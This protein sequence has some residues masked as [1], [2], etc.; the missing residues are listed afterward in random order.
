MWILPFAF[1]GCGRGPE[2]AD[3]GSALCNVDAD[4]D[5]YGASTAVPASSCTDEG[6]ADNADDC[7]DNAASI[8]PGATETPADGIDQDCNGDD[9]CYADV[10]GDGF[11]SDATAGPAPGCE[12]AGVAATN[13]DCDDG[14]IAVHPGAE[15]IPVDAIDQDCDGGDACFVD[16]DGDDFG[17]VI[18]TSSI[19][20]DCADAGESDAADDCLDVGKGAAETFPGSAE[21]DSQ[22]DC[23]TDVDGDGYG[24]N[25]P[26]KG[27]TA[28]TD[29]DDTAT[30]NPCS[31]FHVGYDVVFP[32]S[33]DC[34]TLP[35]Y[36]MGVRVTVD[37][38][39][40][41]TAFGHMA[42][43]SD[44]NVRMA[45]YTDDAGPDALVV[46]A[47]P[48]AAVDGLLELP[49]SA[50]TISAGDYWIMALYDAR[51]PIY[52]ATSGPVGSGGFP[53]CRFRADLPFDDPMPD[54]F[55][56]SREGGNIAWN[57]YIVGY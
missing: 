54:P 41:V 31:E 5:G 45:L 21:L 18:T 23:M 26:A 22:T 33:N 50:T 6:V 13:T 19:D 28:G 12:G 53:R 27:V 36:I 4:G 46:E 25:A 17:S 11:G 48:E 57:Y 3:D 14:D 38:A 34:S 7:D 42:K 2:G 39:M 55:G 30:G 8:H 35:D 1:V 24:S 9:L 56:A 40:T 15:E 29:C 49:V 16:A 52:C 10:D 20:M 43:T 37:R 47:G 32:A 51:A 44:V